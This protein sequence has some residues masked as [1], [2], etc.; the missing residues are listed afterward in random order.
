VDSVGQPISAQSPSSDRG[1]KFKLFVLGS[2]GV[3]A[4]GILALGLLWAVTGSMRS[5][6]VTVDAIERARLN[7]EVVKQIGLPIEPGWWVTGSLSNSGPSG[8]ADLAVPLHGSRGSGTLYLRAE[9]VAGE[10][11]YKL[12]EVG[13]GGRK[14]HIQLLT[15]QERGGV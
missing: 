3:A 4:I 6:Q 7:E 9:E 13:I 2:A 14:D 8:R 5:A 12:M 1:R 10:W 15:A 11:H